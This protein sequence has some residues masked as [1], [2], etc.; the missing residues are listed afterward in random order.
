VHHCC[1]S[2][3]FSILRKESGANKTIA[4]SFDSTPNFLKTQVFFINFSSAWWILNEMRP[5]WSGRGRKWNVFPVM[6]HD[7][8]SQTDWR[9]KDV[10]WERKFES[11]EGQLFR[12][13]FEGYLVS[14]SF[15]DKIRPA[16]VKV[17]YKFIDLHHETLISPSAIQGN[18]KVKLTLTESL[19]ADEK[20]GLRG[21][22]HGGR[23]HINTPRSPVT[24]TSH[25]HLQL[26]TV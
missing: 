15:Q 20:C 3:R 22:N 23:F 14:L 9:K 6:G 16:G 1:N 11:K 13:P 7:S 24:N 8:R 17:V 5:T 26:E 18:W 4:G 2:G 12:V 10:R 21:L 19:L 25:P